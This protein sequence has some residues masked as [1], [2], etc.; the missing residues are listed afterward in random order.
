MPSQLKCVTKFIHHRKRNRLI[1]RG[2][3]TSACP[4]CRCLED[5]S[6]IIKCDALYDDQKKFITN[7]YHKLIKAIY[8][9][10]Q[11]QNII[12]FLSNIVN[13][14]NRINTNETMQKQIGTELVFRGMIVTN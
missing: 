1:N 10:S 11:R 4:Q 8:C 9:E 3:T 5:W 14:F 2:F 12:D 7:L 6:H 13:Y